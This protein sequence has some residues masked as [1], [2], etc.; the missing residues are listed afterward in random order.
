MQSLFVSLT[1]FA[2][3][4]D[5]TTQFHCDSLVVRELHD[6]S[7]K[8][9]RRVALIDFVRYEQLHAITVLWSN[10]RCSI[11]AHSVLRMHCLGAAGLLGS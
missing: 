4:V 7:L 1:R 3:W 11:P 5:N 6:G 9:T 2:L 8:C 10:S